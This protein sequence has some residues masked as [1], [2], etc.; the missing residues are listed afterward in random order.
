MPELINLFSVWNA[1]DLNPLG[2][3]FFSL[4]FWDVYLMVID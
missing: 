4:V 1:Y 2:V 3:E